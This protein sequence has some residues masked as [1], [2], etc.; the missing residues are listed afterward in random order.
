[1][2]YRKCKRAVLDEGKGSFSMKVCQFYGSTERD[3]ENLQEY[4]TG[5]VLCWKRKILKQQGQEYRTIA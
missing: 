3:I 2:K 5:S 4:S 1:M